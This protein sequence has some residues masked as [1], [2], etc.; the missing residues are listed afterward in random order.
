MLSLGEDRA[1]SSLKLKRN[2]ESLVEEFNRSEG[3]VCAAVKVTK[4]DSVVVALCTPLMKRVHI[5]L[6]NCGEVC[7]LDTPSASFSTDCRPYFFIS[8][9]VAGG[10]P[11]GVAIIDKVNEDTLFEAFELLKT[12]LPVNAFGGRNL[13]G[14]KIIL[15]RRSQ[16]EQNSLARAFPLVTTIV[17]CLHLIQSVWHSVLLKSITSDSHRA[18]LMKLLKNM[19]HANSQVEMYQR[20]TQMLE[21]SVVSKYPSFKTYVINEVYGRRED[22]L[23]R[24]EKHVNL[25]STYYKHIFTLSRQVLGD[26]IMHRCRTYNMPRLFHFFM[27]RLDNYYKHR[28]EGIISGKPVMQTYKYMPIA[29][30]VDHDK[31]V[32]VGVI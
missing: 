14:P 7:F 4:Q 5:H 25:R 11:L 1:L 32:K 3:E 15:T 26:K 19:V 30:V 29:T 10:L 2:L 28:L 24:W 22:W 12:I 23:D 16:I 27:T 6:D 18:R 20:M 17:C 31:N 8:H 13:L 9:S 21:D